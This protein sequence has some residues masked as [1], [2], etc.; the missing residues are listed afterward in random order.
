MKITKTEK[1]NG[2]IQIELGSTFL[3]VDHRGRVYEEDGNRLHHTHFDKYGKNAEKFIKE[4]IELQDARFQ[5]LKD[6]V[7]AD[8]KESMAHGDDTTIDDILSF[9]PYRNLVQALPEERWTEF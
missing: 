4:C 9:V 3:T 7:I 8:L 1:G 6:A 2:A 5:A